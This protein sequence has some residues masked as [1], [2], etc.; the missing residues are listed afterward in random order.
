MTQRPSLSAP[1]APGALPGSLQLKRYRMFRNHGHLTADAAAAAP[2]SLAEAIL[3][4][5]AEGYE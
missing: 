2:M 4:D 5:K 3:T 1:P